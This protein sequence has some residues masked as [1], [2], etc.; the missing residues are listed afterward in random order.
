MVVAFLLRIACFA[1]GVA[2]CCVQEKKAALGSP[3]ALKRALFLGECCKVSSLAEKIE[4]LLICKL[5]KSQYGDALHNIKS[6][7]LKN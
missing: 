5:N 2:V 7:S 3:L 6:P 4:K 1:P